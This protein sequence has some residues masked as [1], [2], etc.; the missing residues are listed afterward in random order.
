[1]KLVTSVFCIGILL[2]QFIKGQENK[3]IEIIHANSIE[4]NK[5]S[6]IEAKKLLG[7]VEMKHENI[8]MTCDSAYLYS[9]KNYVDAFSNIHIRQGDTLNLYG[10]LLHYDGNA[11]IAKMKKN[12]SLRDKETLLTTEYLDFKIAENVAYYYNGGKIVNADN[13]L[14]SQIGNYYTREKLFYYRGNVVIIN[15]KYNI[16]SDTL[17]YNTVS[18]IAFFLGPTNIFSKEDTIYCENGWY[19]TQTDI[20]QFN[21]NAYLK[22]NGKLLKGDSLYYE[23]QIGTGRAFTNIELIDTSRN[24]I[25]KGNYAEYTEHPEY[26]MITD[27]AV[28]MQYNNKDT[29]FLHADTLRSILTD[30]VT[31]N[32]IIIAFYK[33]KLFKTDMSGK[34]DSMSYTTADSSIRLYGHPVLWSGVNQLTSDSVQLFLE[35]KMLKEA[36]LYNSA[37]IISQE[38]SSKYDQIQG[39]NMIGFFNNNELYKVAVNGNGQTIYYAKDKDDQIGVN[40]AESSDLVIYRKNGK[41]DRILLLKK[42]A[43]ILYPLNKVSKEELILKGFKWYKLSRP[44]SEKDIFEWTNE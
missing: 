17:K 9:E 30:T 40:K 37:F 39:K 38:D 13:T 3:H 34:C 43:A 31:K 22:S 33:V 4:Y 6:G 10:Q 32:H 23:R 1:M 2:C 25:L 18:H 7:E 35:N 11:K 12:V 29:L 14:T 19:N 28:M 41:I 36:R 5:N 27:S 20:S 21:K 24:L 44:L 8:I 15:P 16:Y 42:P 26:S